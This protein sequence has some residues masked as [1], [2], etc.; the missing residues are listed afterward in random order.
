MGQVVSG[1]IVNF[2]WALTQQPKHRAVRR[3]DDRGGDRRGDRGISRC[4]QPALGHP[5]ALPWIRQHQQRR[6]RVRARH[7]AVRGRP[8]HD[9]LGGD[10]Q[11]RPHRRHRQPLLHH[12]QRWRRTI[13]A[14]V[15]ATTSTAA[16]AAP[17]LADTGAPVR[18]RTGYAAEAALEDV[19]LRGRTRRIVAHEL[20]RVEI[21]V[22]P[23]QAILD[24]TQYQRL[25]RGQRRA[26]PAAGRLDARRRDGT[27]RVATRRR[28]RRH[29]SAAVRAHRARRPR[30]SDR[31][32][33]RAAAAA[34]QRVGC[35]DGHRYADRGR[36]RSARS[37]LRD[38]RSIAAQSRAPASTRCTCGPIP[39]RARVRRRSSWARP[40]SACRA[41][42]SARPTASAMRALAT[43]SWSKG[44]RPAP[45]ILA[46][47]PHSTVTGQFDGA[48]VVRVVVK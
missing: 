31:G 14:G 38:G 48:T 5:N 46:V 30:R 37:S 29:V 23:E 7:D 39:T 16:T 20:E 24:G 11:R 40:R 2:G 13:G 27:L 6:R 3:I 10:R 12:R 33:S 21:A 15:G 47:F 8:A 41:P 19:P 1:T 25:S 35:A 36:D 34:S 32:R 4:A 17:V 22:A 18:A 9:H 45:T 44:S 42:T 26:S 43:S 28:L